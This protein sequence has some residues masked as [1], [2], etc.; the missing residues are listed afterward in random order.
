MACEQLSS[1]VRL[2]LYTCDK[3]SH[4]VVDVEDVSEIILARKLRE[5]GREHGM[6]AQAV[7]LGSIEMSQKPGAKRTAK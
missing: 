7:E 4:C 5:L 1:E 6:V 2:Q 3:L